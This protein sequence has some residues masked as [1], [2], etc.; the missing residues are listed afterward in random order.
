MTGSTPLP[1]GAHLSPLDADDAPALFE[2][3]LRNREHLSPFDPERPDTFW[4]LDGQQAR[5]DSLLQK[6]EAGSTL[7]CAI[8][9]DGRILGCATLDTIVRGPACSAHLGYWVDAGELRQGL[10]GA[11]VAALCRIADEE[12]RLHRI[13][14]STSVTNLGSQRVLA[15]NGFE[16]FGLARNYIHING[17]WQDSRL[18]QRILNDRPP[19]VQ[20]GQ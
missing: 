5:L 14:A 15:R 4:Q 11:A 13:A 16:E 17:R 2:A 9:R 12:L 8:R 7:A 1:A 18:F 19:G 3:Y 10:A 20:P 6:Q